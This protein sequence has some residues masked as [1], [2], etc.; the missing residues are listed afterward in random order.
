MTLTYI[1]NIDL[2]CVPHD[3]LDEQNDG[4]VETLEEVLQ[5]ISSFA[6]LGNDDS[7]CHREHNQ[8]DNV[9]TI[10]IVVNL[11]RGND[12]MRFCDVTSHFMQG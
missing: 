11:A 3:G 2:D 1:D 10:D 8:S 4:V 6:Q 7:Q 9:C 5:G 12:L